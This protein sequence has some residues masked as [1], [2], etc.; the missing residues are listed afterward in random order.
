MRN[1]RKNILLGCNRRLN[2]ASSDAIGVVHMVAWICRLLQWR[3]SHI[4]S[5]LRAMGKCSNNYVQYTWNCAKAEQEQEQFAQYSVSNFMRVLN[6]VIQRSLFL[7][8]V[9]LQTSNLTC[10]RDNPRRQSLL[11]Y[12]PTLEIFLIGFE[13]IKEFWILDVA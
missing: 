3:T 12:H 5:I 10:S 8:I 1:L 9:F 13:H 11:P 6:A 4:F 2:G 7:S